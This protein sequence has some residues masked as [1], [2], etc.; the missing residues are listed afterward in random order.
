VCHDCEDGFFSGPKSKG[1]VD[2]MNPESAC[3][4]Q[5]SFA[6]CGSATT[7][8][9]DP[10]REGFSGASNAEFLHFCLELCDDLPDCMAVEL[11]DDGADGAESGDT[12][13]LGTRQSCSFKSAYTGQSTD[14]SK[15]CYS[16]ICRQ[17]GRD[18]VRAGKVLTE[19][20]LYGFGVGAR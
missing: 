2:G 13:F 5:K 14:W 6:A 7:R 10:R 11:A 8:E 3:C 17:L 15:D 9:R 19:E 4:Y 18:E 12:D 16:N 1:G 20:E